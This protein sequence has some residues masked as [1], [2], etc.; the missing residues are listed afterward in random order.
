MY[1]VLTSRFFAISAFSSKQEIGWYLGT[2][3]DVICSEAVHLIHF[4]AVHTFSTP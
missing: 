2:E 3:V 4:F 1:F